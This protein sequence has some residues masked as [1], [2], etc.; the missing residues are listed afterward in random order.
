MSLLEREDRNAGDGTRTHTTL[1]SP[2][3]KG[4]ASTN[5]ATPAPGSGGIIHDSDRELEA[6]ITIAR[7]GYAVEAF[8]SLAC[9]VSITEND[10]EDSMATQRVALF[11][12]GSNMFYAQ[13]DNKWHIDYKRVY[14]YVMENRDKAAA[15]YFTASPAAGD[16]DR[17]GKYRG[18]KTALINIG[19]SVVD[20][21]V[22][23]LTDEKTGQTKLKGNLDIDL[24]FHMLTEADS[25]D[26]A[27]LMGGD[28]DYV[29]I[30]QHLRHSGKQVTVIGRRRSTATDV[31]NAAT[32]FHDLDELRS[33]IERKSS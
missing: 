19:Y 13:R 8:G 1:R 14:D 28:A 17:I 3:S 20:K 7:Q 22:K 2:S 21:E 27:V 18:F 31:L 24:V 26:V 25:Y 30:I 29:P 15:Y 5:F 16:S 12:D 10:I 6:P 11:V 23:V 33:K 32:K 9:A 4:G